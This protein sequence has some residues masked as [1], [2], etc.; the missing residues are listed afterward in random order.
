MGAIDKIVQPFLAQRLLDFLFTFRAWSSGACIKL[1]INIYL[2]CRSCCSQWY[3]NH[4]ALDYDTGRIRLP[5]NH[6]LH[7]FPKIKKRSNACAAGRRIT[8]K[9]YRSSPISIIEK[10]SLGIDNG[11]SRMLEA[12]H[13]RYKKIKENNYEETGSTNT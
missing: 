13:S 7:P 9:H 11:G 8:R 2:T 10:I 1:A 12:Y 5:G 4:D 6:C 3:I